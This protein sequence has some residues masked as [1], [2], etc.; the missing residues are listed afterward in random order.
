MA[1]LASTNTHRR[2]ALTCGTQHAAPE[3][4]GVIEACWVPSA[5]RRSGRLQGPALA[6]RTHARSRPEKKDAQGEGDRLAE[7]VDER[8]LAAVVGRRCVERE[9]ERRQEGDG[10]PDRGEAELGTQPGVSLRAAEVNGGPESAMA[11][12]S[13]LDQSVLIKAPGDVLRG[14]GLGLGPLNIPSPPGGG[15]GGCEEDGC[16]A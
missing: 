12:G 15:C 14:H 7:P 11:R 13:P 10:E 6:T 2:G 5:C 1:Q 9:V 4:T 16:C 8:L 3:R